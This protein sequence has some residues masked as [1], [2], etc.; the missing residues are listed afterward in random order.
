MAAMRILVCASEAP[1][2]PYNGLRLQIHELVRA[3][4]REHEVC[5]LAFRWPDQ[6]GSTAPGVELLEVPTPGG[7]RVL[8]LAGWARAAGR[9]EPIEAVRVE[10]R[11]AAAIRALR[12]RRTFDVAHVTIGQLAGVADALA[13]LPALLAPLDAWHLNV[14]ADRA[15]SSGPRAVALAVHE[16]FVRRFASTA[17][18]PYAR[19]VFVTDEDAA[20]ARALEPGLPTV[21]IPNGVDAEFFGPRPHVPREAGLVVFTG[22]LDAASNV[23]AATRL[24]RRVMPRVRERVPGAR[25]AIVGRRPTAAVRA[26]GGEPGVEVVGEVPDIRPWLWRA[27]AYACP[28]STG[29][30]M[31]NKLLEALAC[32]APCVATPLATQGIDA[33]PDALTVADDDA[34]LAAGVAAL[35]GDPARRA[36]QGAAGRAYVEA[37]HAWPAVAEAYARVYAQIAAQPVPA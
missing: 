36:H 10:R 7:G 25:L 37:E 14:A 32:G 19:V 30:G 11:M 18:R 34:G 21:V 12:T 22:A 4:A 24:A 20:A 35:L 17:Y 16:H 29:T 3:L 8:R 26:L 15:V 31:K 13:G 5:V 1:L 28:M 33:P 6:H 23:A 9:R 27:E 2:P